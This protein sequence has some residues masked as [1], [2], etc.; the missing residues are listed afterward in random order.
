MGDCYIV[1]RGGFPSGNAPLY[2]YTGQ[3]K[4]ISAEDGS[5]ALHL[6]TSGTLTMQSSMQVDVIAMGA[7]GAGV[8]AGGVAVGGGGYHVTHTVSLSRG[9]PYAIVIGEGGDEIGE[10]GGDTQAFGLTASGGGAA[11]PGEDAYAECTVHSTS[12]T[13]G[14]L[15]FYESLTADA[16][17]RGQ[18]YHNVQL[19]YPLEQVKHSNGSNVYAAH[20][21]GYYRCVVDS[22]DRIVYTDG[23]NGT[24]GAAVTLYGGETAGGPGGTAEA[25]RIAQGGGTVNLAG[26]NGIVA[27]RKA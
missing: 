25:P 8:N 15:Y 13:A 21:S 7:G 18:G 1:R 2:T 19:K 22:T 23:V 5:W 11:T 10:N 9:V 6:L 14:N 3:H 20:P 27:M 26:G 24:G 16:V 17:S 4:L 12:G